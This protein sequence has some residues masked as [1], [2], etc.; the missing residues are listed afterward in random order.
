MGEVAGVGGG[1]KKNKTSLCNCRT[2]HV[3]KYIFSL[4]DIGPGKNKVSTIYFISFYIYFIPILHRY[5]CVYIYIYIISIYVR[6]ILRKRVFLWPL[7]ILF[8]YLFV[9]FSS[10]YLFIVCSESYVEVLSSFM[11]IFFLFG[12]TFVY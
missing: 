12:I 4:I 2:A 11:F 1:D 7:A 5:V 10:L 3:L 8:L 6:R 9:F